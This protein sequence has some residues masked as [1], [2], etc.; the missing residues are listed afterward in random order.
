MAIADAGRLAKSP[1]VPVGVVAAALILVAAAVRGC[2]P[3]RPAGWIG[4][5]IDLSSA[6]AGSAAFWLV[7]G[8]R[9]ARWPRVVLAVIVAVIVGAAWWL[10]A[11]RA[12]GPDCI[13]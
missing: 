7:V 2:D 6:L 12:I 10:V 11:F 9:R 4:Y 5:A 8:R 3:E 1:L 13:D